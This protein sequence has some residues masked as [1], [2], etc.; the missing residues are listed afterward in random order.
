MV[1]GVKPIVLFNL[2]TLPLN[3]TQLA[4]RLVDS[5]V[6]ASVHLRERLQSSVVLLHLGDVVDALLVL[7]FL[8]HLQVL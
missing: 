8:Q 1:P 6:E 5:I 2:F 3:H 7:Q 4:V